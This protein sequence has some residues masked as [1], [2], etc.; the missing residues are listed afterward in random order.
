MKFIIL[1]FALLPLLFTACDPY[2]TGVTCRG[3]LEF[4]LPLEVVG[5]K[6][7]LQIGDTLIF[8]LAFPDQLNEH[9]SGVA[10]DFLDYDF[11]LSTL[12]GRIDSLPISA[13]TKDYFDFFVVKGEATYASGSYYIRPEYTDGFYEFEA[14]YVAK[15]AGL[16]GNSTIS[17][18]DRHR[19][20]KKLE[21]PCCKDVVYILPEY[22]SIH[23]DNYDFMKFSP[24]DAQANVDRQRFE[25]A[26][27]FCFFVR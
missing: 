22:V 17:N 24:S 3:Q 21:G 25:E 2:D 11:R 18:Y 16:F 8:R 14:F 5:L 4:H 10:Y 19:P 1:L 26:A 20:L 27:G 12:L 7:T 23:S 15:R 6:D 13:A 9:R